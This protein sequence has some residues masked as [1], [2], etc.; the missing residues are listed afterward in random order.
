MKPDINQPETWKRFRKGDCEGCRSACC[1]MPVE[2]FAEDLVR[3]ELAEMEE[4]EDGAKAVAKRLQKKGVIASFRD[5]T[6]VFLLA[7][8]ADGSCVFLNRDRR[9]EVYDQRPKTCREFPRVS[10]RPG[11]CPQQKK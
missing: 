8:Q 6:G 7:R 10:S 2:V 9:C 1:T 3:L 4:F 5:R 11:F